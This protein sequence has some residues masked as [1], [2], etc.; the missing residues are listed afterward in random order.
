MIFVPLW[1]TGLWLC[2][3]HELY[4]HGCLV[5]YSAVFSHGRNEAT[6]AIAQLGP[7]EGKPTDQAIGIR[8]LQ[9]M[10]PEDSGSHGSD[11]S[12]R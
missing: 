8:G 1:V 7:E 11:R 4:D 9:A 2:A 5:R 3:S 10:V 12:H 6:K